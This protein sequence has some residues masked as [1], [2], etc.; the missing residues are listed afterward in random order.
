M[1]KNGTVK[2]ENEEKM[3]KERRKSRNLRV[4]RTLKGEALFFIYFFFCFSLSGND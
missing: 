2:E 4:K 3:K 1:R